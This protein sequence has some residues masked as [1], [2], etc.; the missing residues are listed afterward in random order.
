MKAEPISLAT[1][2]DFA[3]VC[4]ITP[5]ANAQW[6]SLSIKTVCYFISRHASACGFHCEFINR[7]LTPG[8]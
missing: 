4:P 1:D 5:E 2:V 7:R 8:G 6:Y 3:K